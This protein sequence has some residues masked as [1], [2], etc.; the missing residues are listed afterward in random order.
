MA[1]TAKKVNYMI[2]DDI[3]KEFEELVP[4]GERSKIVNEAIRKELLIIKRK[5]LTEKL[6]SLRAIGKTLSTNEIVETIR[7]DRLRQG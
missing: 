7:K 3:R 6:F 5:K 2:N 4:A 1:Q